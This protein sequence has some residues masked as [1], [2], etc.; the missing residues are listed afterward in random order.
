MNE[1]GLYKSLKNLH[2]NFLKTLSGSEILMLFSGG[3]DSSVALDFLIQAGAEFGFE[4]SVQAGAYPVHRYPVEERQRISDYWRKRGAE[5][6]WH[7]LAAN[8]SAIENV[9][10]P[11]GVCQKMRKKMLARFLEEQNSQ[12]DRLVIVTSYSLWDLVSYSLEQVLGNMLNSGLTMEK[13]FKETAQRFFPVLHMKEGYRVF[14]PLVTINDIDIQNHLE[15]LRIP[16]L[17]AECKFS[18]LRPKRIL[19]DYY[20]TAGFSFD[21]NKLI[22]FVETSLDMPSA[23]S[24]EF[25]AREE[26]LNRLF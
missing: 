4:P 9:Q 11:C 18:R 13:R 7:E 20:K 26:Y 1:P 14:R 10:N 12:W 19:E 8:D 17:A 23:S 16:T 6:R 25:I 15:K 3:K 22:N 5:I 21:Y 2:N 24:Y